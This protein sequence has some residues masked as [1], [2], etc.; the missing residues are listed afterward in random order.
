ML[1]SDNN[2]IQ[3]LGIYFY[4]FIV[5]LIGGL[6]NVGARKDK[7]TARKYTDLGIGILSSGFFGW[8]GFEVIN[9]LYQNER[10][11]LA[12]CGFF[13]WKGAV[14]FGELIDKIVDT[15]LKRD[16]NETYDN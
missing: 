11:A 15:K 9:F 14:W 12:G 5:G 7:S 1:N 6:L 13:A 4:V 10:L 2:I 3:S 8:I 16:N